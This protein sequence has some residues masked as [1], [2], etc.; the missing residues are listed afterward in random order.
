MQSTY[1]KNLF[2]HSKVA[3]KVKL[4]HWKISKATRFLSDG[5]PAIR[6]TSTWCM[7]SVFGMT[8]AISIWKTDISFWSRF[9]HCIMMFS[10]LKVLSCAWHYKFGCH[11]NQLLV[12]TINVNTNPKYCLLI[13]LST[14]IYVR[15]YTWKNKFKV[16]WA[17]LFCHYSCLI[18]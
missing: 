17:Y 6:P 8:K 1:S 12:H 11:I 10:S 5:F 13:K 3:L 18:L 16:F 15:F 7:G 9:I 2:K 14:S 4:Y